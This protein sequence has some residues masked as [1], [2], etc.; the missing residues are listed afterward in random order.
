MR[1]MTRSDDAALERLID[2]LTDRIVERED[3][4]S[5]YVWLL[6]NQKRKI[7]EMETELR[8]ARKRI[9]ELENG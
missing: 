1:F 2:R 5:G 4:I 9:R 6:E 3:K 7:H 8:E